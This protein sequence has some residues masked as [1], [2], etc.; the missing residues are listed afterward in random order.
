MTALNKT[1]ENKSGSG[2]YRHYSPKTKMVER[3][4]GDCLYG[5][6][7]SISVDGR[8][9]VVLHAD[10]E[11]ELM[12][13]IEHYEAA[14]AKKLGGD[15]GVFG[16]QKRTKKTEH[17]SHEQREQIRDYVKSNAKPGHF[18]ANLENIVDGS[19]ELVLNKM[20]PQERGELLTWAASLDRADR[21]K[22]GTR[23]PELT[24]CQHCD[25]DLS[26]KARKAG[27]A[28][29]RDCDF[30]DDGDAVQDRIRSYAL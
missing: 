15:A 30:L 12:A 4:T 16:T 20:T 14:E 1:V 19:G 13:K 28:Y 3:C 23:A 7:S 21:I 18:Q 5:Q 9:F 11:E 22:K 27:K 29:C 10:S 2:Y 24:S 17:F 26:W 6:N 8:E 25:E